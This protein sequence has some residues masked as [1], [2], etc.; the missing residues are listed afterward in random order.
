MNTHCSSIVV[1]TEGQTSGTRLGQQP[2]P[3]VIGQ[4]LLHQ[5]D[6]IG[7]RE[8][9]LFVYQGEHTQRFLPQITEPFTMLPFSL[10][11]L[12]DNGEAE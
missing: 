12:L 10:L 7:L 11:T 9:G 8:S 4:H 5:R 6:V 2:R 1:H 3:P